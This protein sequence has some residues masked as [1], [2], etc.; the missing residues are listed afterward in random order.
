MRPSDVPWGIRIGEVRRMY[1]LYGAL[2]IRMGPIWAEWGMAK[3]SG[4]LAIRI[5]TGRE[6]GLYYLVHI[7]APSLEYELYR[8]NNVSSLCV[9]VCL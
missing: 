8:D 5:G 2:A 4:P 6:S 9:H 7:G 3:C 1:L